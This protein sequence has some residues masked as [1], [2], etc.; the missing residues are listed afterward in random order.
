MSNLHNN[1]HRSGVPERGLF[2]LGFY[3]DQYSPETLVDAALSSP[4]AL[5]LNS[6]FGT[7]FQQ[8]ISLLHT[9][10]AP[11]PAEIPANRSEVASAAQT[12]GAAMA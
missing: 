5:A 4:E 9:S 2:V 1:P 12:R 8:P 10:I 11:L 3:R 6:R 7:M